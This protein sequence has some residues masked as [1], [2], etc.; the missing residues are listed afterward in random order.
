MKSYAIIGRH[1]TESSHWLE[2][3]LINLIHTGPDSH[4]LSSV[5]GGLMHFLFFFKDLPES[6]DTSLAFLLFDNRWTSVQ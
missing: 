3:S 6:Y 4:F 1:K 5:H 2:K